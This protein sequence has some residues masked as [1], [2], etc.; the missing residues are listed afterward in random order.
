MKGKQLFSLL[1]ALMGISMSHFLQGKIIILFVLSYFIFIFW[2]CEKKVVVINL[3]IFAFFLQYTVW[4]NERNV[5]H[6]D[7]S[8]QY[9][10]GVLN[11]EVHI[12][13]DRLSSTLKLAHGEK[14]VIYYTIP[15]LVEKHQL[16]Q[17]KPGM[18]CT[19][20]GT[21]VKPNSARNPNGFDY[22]R[23]LFHKKI[24]WLLEIKKLKTIQC[25][26]D[27]FNLY[28]FTLNFRV[29]GIK[30]IQQY[31]PESI[32]G[33]VQ[34]LIFGDKRE[35]DSEILNAYQKLGVIHILAISG[36]HVGF[37][38]GMFYFLLI[39]IGFTKERSTLLL[40]IFLP[41][42]IVLTGV[43]PSVVRASFM[44]MIF[45]I[46]QKSKLSLP[47]IDILSI[48]CLFLLV[49]N[50]S[51]I[52][53]IGFQLSFTVAAS[54]LLSTS[55]FK[56]KTNMW[57]EIL[58]VSF[59]AQIS[60]LPIILFYF[61]EFNVLSV[62]LNMIYVPIYSIVILPYCIVSFFVLLLFPSLSIILTF[63]L[64]KVITLLDTLALWVSKLQLF[65]VT[66]GKPS[67]LM[68]VLYVSSILF[69]L[70]SWEKKSEKKRLHLALCLFICV[71]IVHYFSPY[72]QRQ[73]Y[74]T[75]LDVGQGDSIV[76]ELP[77]RRGVYIIDTGGSVVFQK[78]MWKQ[79]QNFYEVGERVITPYLKSKGI[80]K[81]N[82]LILTH[83]DVDHIGG[84]KYIIES[85]NVEEVI[86]PK[87]PVDQFSIE[88]QN[89]ILEKGISLKKGLAGMKWGNKD[90]FFEVISPTNTMFGSKNNRSIVIQAELG[91]LR[92]L[93]TGD[94][95]EEG[96]RFLLINKKL[97]L[98]DVL[99]VGHHGSKTS[100]S[101]SF[102]NALNPKVAIISTGLNNRF[103]HP[104]NEV[105]NR[106]Q[107][108]EIHVL[109]TDQLGAVQYIFND[110][111]GTFKWELP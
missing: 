59:T 26:E 65:Q 81:I 3:C 97:Q 89:F 17:L 71:F 8:Q 44:A 108:N 95:E 85:L 30:Y 67:V 12:D 54:L 79:R 73:G 78:E 84:A 11:E 38:C 91:R 36:L 15:S 1:S 53:S 50:P 111:V 4:F 42:Y 109:R 51:Y 34:A 68:L 16:A 52:F 82:K 32:N 70:V 37:I 2:R 43:S 28:Y 13:G 86:I 49:V 102:L 31:F 29:Q 10:R 39:R 62:L 76:I 6:I 56:S 80:K 101:I 5:S 40:I 103:G 21:L 25:K 45:I 106:L 55:I 83:G 92:W 90:E 58:K 47:P 7:E 77:K 18:T 96:E 94:L 22:Q 23:F 20:Q 63:P 60:S 27:N 61:Y 33:T 14:V 66:L 64:Q 46:L 72:V 48:V 110:E 104:H 100:T 57:K 107:V 9:F 75:F 105:I 87:V 35:I 93:F 74:V 88:L 98:I 41:I 69:V 19:F 24:H 99:K